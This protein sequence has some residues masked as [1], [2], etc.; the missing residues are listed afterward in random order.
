V[1]Y[2][3]SAA[4][5]GPSG[6]LGT[7]KHL[8]LRRH[9]ARVHD[10]Q[11]ECGAR[12]NELLGLTSNSIDWNN[13]IATLESTENGDKRHLLLN[14]TALNPLRSLPTRLDGQLFPFKPNQVSVAVRRA[15]RL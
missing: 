11:F 8:P 1:V 4:R 2:Y 3:N 6:G 5:L 12:R 13:R 10:R 9:S 14:D 15:G 7:L